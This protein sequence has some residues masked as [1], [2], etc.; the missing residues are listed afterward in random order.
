MKLNVLFVLDAADNVLQ[1]HPEID[2]LLDF[3]D[4][5][6]CWRAIVG[7][8]FVGFTIA[9]DDGKSA[10]ELMGAALVALPALVGMTGSLALLAGEFIVQKGDDGY[11]FDWAG[12][13]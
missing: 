11:T 4:D 6:W 10:E 7:D 5:D 9:A 12:E 2:T 1:M 13:A 8:K 3:D